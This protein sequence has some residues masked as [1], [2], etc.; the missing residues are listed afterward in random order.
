LLG[1]LFLNSCGSN[2]DKEILDNQYLTEIPAN[3]GN[4]GII[5]NP[6]S[7][8][9]LND[10]NQLAKIQFDES[11]FDFGKV[12]TGEKVTHVY[13]FKNIGSSP[14]IINHASANCGC[15]VPEFPKEPILPGENEV[16]KVIFDTQGRKGF[17]IKKINIFANTYPSQNILELKGQIIE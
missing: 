1:F 13:K 6:I 12:V 7:L 15:T 2:T 14:L 3:F 9:G 8:E 11:S 10:S 5:R 4:A 16:I 17:Q